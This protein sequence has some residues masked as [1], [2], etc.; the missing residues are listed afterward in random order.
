MM[1]VLLARSGVMTK[2]IKDGAI[3]R[4]YNAGKFYRV[5][6]ADVGSFA[7]MT[8]ALDK[9]SGIPEAGIIRGDLLPGVNPDN[10]RRLC[11]KAEHGDA[12]TFGPA[13]RRW[14]G[15]DQD[16]IEEPAGL[17]FASHPEEGVEHA[18]GLL[19]EPFHDASCWWQATSGGGV[20]PGINVRLWFWFN[21]LVSDSECKGWLKPFGA[22]VSIYQP[23]GIH[24]VA[25]PI[26]L[27]GP[28]PMARRQGV[29][30]GLDDT[31]EV[32][33]ELPR[34]ETVEPIHVEVVLKDL[35][36]TEQRRIAAAIKNSP[37]AR[38]IWAGERDYP[39]RSSRHFA[40]IGGLLRAGIH[41][42]EGWQELIAFAV[43]KL[44][45]KLGIDT[46]K[47]T[48]PDYIGRT[49]GA[50]LARETAR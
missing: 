4:N 21:R 48:R 50:V 16:Q 23:V 37:V 10:C 2:T 33:A 28:D 32:P 24:Y 26:I 27:S 25:A 5:R 38:E 15:I 7:D 9:A 43:L 29:R 47:A 20:K 6:H 34:V 11:N 3:A 13:P 8:R 17:D 41:D 39:D 40:F 45:Q 14:I 12:V 49:I 42:F 19:P 31:V 44:D 18:I 22:D 1:T 36:E 30:R 35:S 46:S